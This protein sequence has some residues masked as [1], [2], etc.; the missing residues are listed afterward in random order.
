MESA[1]ALAKELGL[2]NEVSDFYAELQNYTVNVEGHNLHRM[3]LQRVPGNCKN[4][5]NDYV[6]IASA[7]TNKTQ[8]INTVHIPLFRSST[9]V[10][11]ATVPTESN[12]SD[13]DYLF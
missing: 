13:R 6:D 4:K 8:P 1:A 9:T 2:W 3:P 7:D 11:A 12:C 5:S 10:A